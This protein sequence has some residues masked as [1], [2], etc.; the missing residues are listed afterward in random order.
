F[1]RIDLCRKTCQVL[2]PFL[3]EIEWTIRIRR[4]R[5]AEVMHRSMG[6]RHIPSTPT[7]LERRTMIDAFEEGARYKRCPISR[8]IYGRHNQPTCRSMAIEAFTEAPLEPRFLRLLRTHG[9]EHQ[10]L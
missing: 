6:P 10:T 9:V 3:F 1:S 4:D 7:I 2:S 5:I 8:R